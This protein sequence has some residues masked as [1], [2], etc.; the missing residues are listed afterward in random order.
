NSTRPALHGRVEAVGRRLRA[1][2]QSDGA[3][4]VIGDSIRGADGRPAVAFWIPG[5]SQARRHVL[6]IPIG[7]AV[8]WKSRI[9]EEVQTC[10]GVRIHGAV[11][12]GVES[13]IVIVV[14]VAF[15]EE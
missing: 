2:S 9:A 14:D 5:E 8:L 7:R 3:A 10:R 11:D 4:E 6:H 1:S 15:G 12:A 13:S